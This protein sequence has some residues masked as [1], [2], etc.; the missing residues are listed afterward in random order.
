MRPLLRRILFTC[1]VVLLA[2]CSATETS[3][4]PETVAHGAP[5]SSIV[6]PGPTM[7]EAGCELDPDCPGGNSDP[8]PNAM[9]YWLGT[10][11]TPTKCFDPSG[12]TI[13]DIDYD[14][15]N[16]Y[17]ERML[18]EHFRP[19][20]IYHP[21]DCNMGMEPYW[22][23]KYFENVASNPG[24]NHRVARVAYLFSYYLDCG[25]PSGY[26]VACTIQGLFGTAFTLGGV[27]P[28]WAIGPLPVTDEDLCDGHWGDSEFVILDIEY[29]ED[30]EHW[31]TASAFFSAHWMTEGDKSRR[32]TWQGGLQF[33]DKTGG[34]P[35]VWVAH[36]KHAN[37]P[38]RDV[39]EDDGQFADNCA[40]NYP[41][42]RPRYG[43][44]YN[45]GSMQAN[46][47]NPGTCVTGGE[48][49]QHY[50]EN[51]GIECFW[52]DTP[53]FAGWDKYD[54]GVT[55]YKT[56]LVAQFECWLLGQPN[57]NEYSCF[58]GNWGINRQGT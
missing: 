52:L 46:L 30:T 11:T 26:G 50:P 34:Y 12:Q 6:I 25:A 49:V 29:N 22:A 13:N 44:Q 55:P 2:S 28:A 57:G 17:C 53:H 38:S 58:S 20:L 18:A 31:F 54:A 9:G 16:D 33:P 36:G 39:C 56:P 45:V 40:G 32:V 43:P 23:A 35:E 1:G 7:T 47:I 48:L 8:Y 19:Q 42:M 27:L 21:F 51:Y 10:S 24:S 15:M 3:T 41:R 5:P 37:Y 14:G 4:A